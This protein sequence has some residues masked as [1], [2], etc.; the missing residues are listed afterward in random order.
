MRNPVKMVYYLCAHQDILIAMLQY[1]MGLVQQEKMRYAVVRRNPPTDQLSI[2]VKLANPTKCK[3]GQSLG[4]CLHP[5]M[6][7]YRVIGIIS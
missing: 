4:L 3:P 5:A 7:Q 1:H 2:Y 6:L